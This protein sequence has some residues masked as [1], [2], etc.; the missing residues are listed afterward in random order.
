M[1]HALATALAE[2]RLTPTDEIEINGVLSDGYALR[3]RSVSRP[4]DFGIINALYGATPPV[5][6]ALWPDLH[7]GFP[8]D[9]GCCL[10]MLVQ[11]LL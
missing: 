7:H 8:G 9:P 1:L 10:P 3:L 2:R 6:Q 5:Y 4:E 11:P